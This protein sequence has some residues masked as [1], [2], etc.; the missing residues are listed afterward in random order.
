MV[1]EKFTSADLFQIALEKSCDYLLIMYV[2]TFDLL[3]LF[4]VSPFVTAPCTR[5]QMTTSL[6][7]G[8]LVKILTGEQG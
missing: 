3:F 1:F 5:L 4:Y 6:P 7:R 8:R 2:Q